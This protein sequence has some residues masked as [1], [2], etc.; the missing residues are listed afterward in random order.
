MVIGG[1]PTGVELAGAL[2]EISRHALAND[3]RAIDPESA[4]VI[5]I[6]GGP[7]VLASYPAD[8]SAF[9]RRALEKLGVAVWTG[10]VVS[11]IEE[12]R[13]HGRG[14]DNRSR[15]HSVGRRRVARRRLGASLGVPLDRAGRVLVEDDLSVPGH[16]EVS[17]VGD[18]A[19]LRSAG[20]AWLPGVA[21]VAMQQAAHAAAQCAAPAERMKPPRPFVYRNLGNLATIGRNSAVADMPR[22]RFKGVPGV[23]LLAVR[24]RLQ[25]DWLPQPCVRDDAVGHCR[26]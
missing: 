14:R 25:P 21:Q 18:L 26:T 10:S 4:R 8:L 5:L 15:D 6:E 3:F 24:P 23:A 2:A 22:W 9:A 13:V 20:G 11:N 16:P 1:G 19:A 12:G 7:A 17:V